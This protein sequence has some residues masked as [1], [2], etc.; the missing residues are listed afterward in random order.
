MVSEKTDTV[1]LSNSIFQRV[2]KQCRFITTNYLNSRYYNP[3][4]G[5]FVNADE[6][7]N[8]GVGRSIQC[9]NLCYYAENNPVCMMDKDVIFGN[10]SIYLSNGRLEINCYC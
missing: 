4:V 3:E 6:V 8:L 2:S 7:T 10:Q 5:R 9:L 1:F